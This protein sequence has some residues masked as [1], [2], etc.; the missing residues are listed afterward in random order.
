MEDIDPNIPIPGVD[1]PSPEGGLPE[2]GD[3]AGDPLAPEVEEENVPDAPIGEPYQDTEVTGENEVDK[4]DLD[5]NDDDLSDNESLLSDVDEAQFQDFDPAAISLEDRQ[6]IAI[7]DDNVKLLGVHKRKRTEGEIDEAARKKKKERRRDKTAKKARRRRDG[8]EPFSG[9]EE[10]DGKRRRRR[11][12]EEGGEGGGSQ[13]REI[14]ESALPP[15]ERKRRELD[16]KMDEALRS[17]K[18]RISRKD[19]IVCLS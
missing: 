5:D 19:G 11:A 10:I 4:D 13:R 16:R 9:G 14:D 17:G 12:A 7:D 15:D 3:D 1:A 18:T 8:S 2:A 6:Q